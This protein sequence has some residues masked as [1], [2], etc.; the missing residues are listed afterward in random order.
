MRGAIVAPAQVITHNP[1]PQRIARRRMHIVWQLIE[2]QIRQPIAGQVLGEADPRCEGQAIGR[3]VSHLCLR[4]QVHDRERIVF[5][6]PES[7]FRDGSQR[8]AP[9]AEKPRRDLVAV[10]EACEDETASR[11][12]TLRA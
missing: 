8:T 2:E 5:Q 10:A 7:A 12:L 3:D 4:A 11:Q 9:D 1:R 6:K